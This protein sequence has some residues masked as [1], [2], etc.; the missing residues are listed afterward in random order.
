MR[1]DAIKEN[2]SSYAP[3][4]PLS[5][6]YPLDF[7]ASDAIQATERYSSSVASCKDFPLPIYAAK[8]FFIESEQEANPKIAEMQKAKQKEAILKRNKKSFWQLFNKETL[9]SWKDKAFNFFGKNKLANIKNA[10][11]TAP[12]TIEPTS[13]L[14]PAKINKKEDIE[15]QRIKEIE[16]TLVAYE[17][18]LQNANGGNMKAMME[19]MCKISI[20]LG[21][22]GHRYNKKE[23]DD[24]FKHLEVN[25]KKRVKTF[26]GGRAWT[27]V[28]VF[29]QGTGAALSFAPLGGQML[30]DTSLFGKVLTN[31]G[32]TSQG[33]SGFG[34]ATSKIGDIESEKKMAARTEHDHEGEKLKQ[35][36]H[37]RDR[38]IEKIHQSSQQLFAIMNELARTHT[39]SV[40]R[41]AAV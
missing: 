39:E 29:L 32:Q 13:E 6:D 4:G 17:L 7:K 18:E 8:D 14:A 21:S 41:A 37:D 20:L 31:L 23:I 36:R 22:L 1:E 30:G 28:S 19:M 34:H 40:K 24:L 5:E 35:T 9:V 2:Y 11:I 38:S 10:S 27:Y 26:E 12:L 16:D 33:I 15:A 3:R 25:V